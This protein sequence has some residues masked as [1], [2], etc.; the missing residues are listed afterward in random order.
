MRFIVGLGL[1]ATG[2]AASCSSY[3]IDQC[4]NDCACQR[5]ACC[6]GAGCDKQGAQ[7]KY[8]TCVPANSPYEQWTSCPSANTCSAFSGLVRTI[9]PCVVPTPEPT[10]GATN[11][12]G[13]LDIPFGTTFPMIGTQELPKQTWQHNVYMGTTMQFNPGAFWGYTD[14][15]SVPNWNSL[16]SGGGGGGSIDGSGNVVTPEP[17]PADATGRPCFAYSQPCPQGYYCKLNSGYNVQQKGTCQRE[18]GDT[19][20]GG[21]GKFTDSSYYTGLTHPPLILEPNHNGV[22]TQS[23]SGYGLGYFGTGAYGTGGYGTDGAYGTA[24]TGAESCGPLP[25]GAPVCGFKS[26]TG[27]CFCDTDCAT[28]GDCC[29]DY[30]NHCGVL[31][32]QYT[33]YNA[34]V[35]NTPAYSPAALPYSPPATS[36]FGTGA[37]SCDAVGQCAGLCGSSSPATGVN[38][39][40]CY[41]DGQC[42]LSGDCCCSISQCS[43]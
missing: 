42:A 29:K 20:T 24:T 8:N 39:K 2:L 32:N 11:N 26:F 41:C 33:G 27:S 7:V 34:P 15:Y 22:A 16:G 37:G 3:T 36:K 9:S 21:A 1:C 19:W 35:S 31:S 17:T 43:L 5:V 6:C 4:A 28:K 14:S 40:P 30:A 25:T 10:P 18:A 23:S 38:G 12:N 13:V